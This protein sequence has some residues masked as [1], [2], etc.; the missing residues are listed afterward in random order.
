MNDRIIIHVDMNSFFATAEQQANPNLRGK[1]VA[2]RGSKSERTIVV[3]SS[4]EAK[5]LG[6]KTGHLI[7]EAK[8]ICPEINIVTG[9]PRK[10][11]YIL[12]QLVN[13]FEK[14]SDK[15]EIFSIDECFLDVTNSANLFADDKKANNKCQSPNVQQIKNSNTLKLNSNW[16]GSINI[17]NLIKNDIKYEVGEWMTCSV[18]IAENKFLA[19]LGSDLKKPDGLVVIIPNHKNQI[20]KNKQSYKFQ[21]QFGNRHCKKS[22]EV[23]PETA[24]HLLK[25]KGASTILTVDEILL[26]SKL[27]DFCGIGKRIEKRLKRMKIN[28]V[29]DLRLASDIKL[30]NGFGIYGLKLKRWSLGIDNSEVISYTEQKEAKSFSKSR[31]LNKN[32]TS[33]TELKKTL[34]LLCEVLGSRMRKEHYWGTTIGLWVK[35]SSFSGI[36]KNKKLKKWICDGHEIFKYAEN[37]LDEIELKQ[38]VRAIGVR[39]SDVQPQ[40][41]VPYLI[42]EEDK[43]DEKIVD[44]IDLINNK[45][46]DLSL[47]RA[48][49]CNMKLKEVVSGMGRKSKKLL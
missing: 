18:G 44:A 1:P 47:M 28:S 17:A 5:R 24:L 23:I 35:Y 19:K 8:E 31:T 12:T 40:K 9:E 26:G 48:S 7:H 10:Y 34:Y 6:I 21:N 11:S 30:K 14:Y 32:V 25:V 38:A 13:I 15:V 39:V 42:F 45:Y 2:V 27:S 29:K 16:D 46:G 3:A 4:I 20:T 22:D 49:V 37:I 33:K 36:G 41:N 43:E